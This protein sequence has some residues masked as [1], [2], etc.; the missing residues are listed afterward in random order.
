MIF[1][2]LNYFPITLTPTGTLGIGT[3]FISQFLYVY[4]LMKSRLGLIHL[5]TL[6]GS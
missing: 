1:I 4:T 3:D 2:V 6:K 5:K